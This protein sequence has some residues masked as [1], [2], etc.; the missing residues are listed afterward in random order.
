MA[1]NESQMDQSMASEFE[2]SQNMSQMSESVRYQEHV[3]QYT[4]E[5][6]GQLLVDI[7]D[8][9]IFYAMAMIVLVPITLLANG[10]GSS[11]STFGVSS[12]SQPLVA[13]TGC[14]IGLDFWYIMLSSLTCVKLFIEVMRY[15]SVAKYHLESIV[16]SLGGN[17]VVMPILF[18]AF[19]VYTQSLFESANPDP[20]HRMTYR[21]AQIS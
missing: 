13:Q 19:F 1:D 14:Q 18:G 3:S 4:L 10:V 16:F 15:L 20:D 11:F 21:E 2:S 6:T 8:R 5:R 7:K 12:Y 17:F 9:I